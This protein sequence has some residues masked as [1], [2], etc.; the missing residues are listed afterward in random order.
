MMIKSLLLISLYSALSFGYTWTSV[1]APYRRYMGAAVVG[2]TAYFAGGWAVNTTDLSSIQIFNLTSKSISTAQFSRPGFQLGVA[3]LNGLVY[4]TGGNYGSLLFDILDTKTMNITSETLPLPAY[5]NNAVVVR[6]LIVIAGGNN[7]SIAIYNTTSKT[8]STT[9]YSL[10]RF[11]LKSVSVGNLVLS[12]GGTFTVQ[13]GNSS[14]YTRAMSDNVDVFDP[15]TMTSTLLYHLSI[16]RT[17]MGAT[18]VGNLAIFAGGKDNDEV[19][20]SVVDIFNSQT[21]QWNV[22]QLSV[23]RSELT[24]TSVNNLAIFAGGWDSAR[25]QATNIVDIYNSATNTWIVN[26]LPIPVYGASAVSIGNYAIVYGFDKIMI[27]D[28][29]SA[30]ISSTSTSSQSTTS[31]TSSQSTSSDDSSDTQALTV[32]SALVLSAMMIFE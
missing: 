14:D 16:A 2:D 32:V 9:P 25:S 26:Q 19:S 12:A 20:S 29:T 4:I 8:F 30:P 15:T 17:E 31:L 24:A 7:A 22:T 1:S 21:K 27:M 5:G 18:A 23:A 28:S 6:D 13:I 3:A 10:A 11:S